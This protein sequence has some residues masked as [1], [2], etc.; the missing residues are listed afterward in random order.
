MGKIRFETEVYEI[1]A[2]RILRFPKR[3]SAELP[4]RGAVMVGGTINGDMPRAALTRRES[5]ML[6]MFHY[7]VFGEPPA[8]PMGEL[9]VYNMNH[10]DHLPK[11]VAIEPEIGLN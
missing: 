3:F 10:I 8:E 11:P 1:N 4:S 7:T 6:L 5:H 9:T 2:W